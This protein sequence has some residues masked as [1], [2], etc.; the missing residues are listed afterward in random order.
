MSMITHL[1]KDR[2]ITNEATIISE[3]KW[4]NTSYI[5]FMKIRRHNAHVYSMSRLSSSSGSRNIFLSA[6]S[7]GEEVGFRNQ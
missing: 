7:V 1:L 5:Y 2:R 6:R 3:E 4:I